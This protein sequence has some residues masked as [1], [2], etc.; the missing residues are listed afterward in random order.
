MLYAI[1]ALIALYALLSAAGSSKPKPTS[2]SSA[3]PSTVTWKPAQT[4]ATTTA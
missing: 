4:T 3:K 2:K 1:I